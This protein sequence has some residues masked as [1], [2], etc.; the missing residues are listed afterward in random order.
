MP[1]YGGLFINEF[2]YLAD[3]EEPEGA[4]GCSEWADLYCFADIDIS[5]VLR[6]TAADWLGACL[7]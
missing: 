5:P 3:I 7:S 6:D 4:R 2:R 1:S